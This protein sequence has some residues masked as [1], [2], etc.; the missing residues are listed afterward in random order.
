MGN[1][2]QECGWEERQTS[3]IGIIISLGVINFIL[4]GYLIYV[5]CVKGKAKEDQNYH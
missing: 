3:W 4:V 2:G 1:V 5:K